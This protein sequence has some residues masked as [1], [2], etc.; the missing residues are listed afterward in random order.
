MMLKNKKMGFDNPAATIYWLS[1]TMGLSLAFVSLVVEDWAGLY[2][3]E[4]FTG[5]AKTLET[6]FFL[7]APGVVAFCMVLSE[8]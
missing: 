2:R 1:P 8:F 6:A 3:S 4:F 5:F 7:S